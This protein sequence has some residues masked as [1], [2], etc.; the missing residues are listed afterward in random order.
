MNIAMPPITLGLI[1]AVIVLIFAILG[2]L[3]VVPLSGLVVFG[4]VAGL[5]I[6]RMT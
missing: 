4:L 2:V 3:S 1:I 6:A 5:A